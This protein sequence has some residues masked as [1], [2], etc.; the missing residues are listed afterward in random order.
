MSPSPAISV[1]SPIGSAVPSP[2]TVKTSS[3]SISPTSFE[4]VFSSPS[5][6]PK[7]TKQLISPSLGIEDYSPPRLAPSPSPSMPIRSPSRSVSR[8]PSKSPSVS[9]SPSLSPSPSFSPSISPSPSPSF[10]P[11]PSISPSW[12]PSP[13][14]SPSPSLPV[15]PPYVPPIKFEPDENMI[16]QSKP[17][18]YQP[19]RG[20]EYQAD[21]MAEVLGQKGKKAKPIGFGLFTGQE[22]RLKVKGFGGSGM[23][24]KKMFGG[25]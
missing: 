18:R 3:P 13:S 4:S 22:R 21:L 6:A 5:V 2:S 1:V 17:K 24:L 12:S 25:L 8:S 14:P 15:E 23:K 19:P 10:S 20:F 11:S 9:I 16:K 7:V